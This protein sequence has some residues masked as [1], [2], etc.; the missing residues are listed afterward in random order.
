MTRNADMAARFTRSMMPTYGAPAISLD[1]GDGCYVYDVE[2]NAYLD[3]IA[4]IA[5]SSLGHNH[6][7]I[8]QAVKHQVDRLAHSSNLY[9]H[10]PG[11]ALA[12]KLIELVDA[13]AKVFFVNSGAEANECALKLAIR[14][15]K[16]TGRRYFVAA[17]DG[18]HG[19]TLGAL[20]LSGKASIREPFGPYGIDVHFVPYGDVD[21]IQAA[22]SSECAAV[23]IEP[24][25]GE[26][27]VVWPS[28][29]YLKAV[30]RVCDG[31]GALYIADEIQSGI[32][33]SGQWFAYHESQARPDILTLAKGLAGGLPLGACIALSPYGEL[34]DKGA[35]GST[36]G[37]N[38]VS[39]AAAMAVIETIEKQDLV[40]KSAQ[41]GQHLMDS[42]EALDH[43]LIDEVRGRGLWCAIVLASDIAGPVQDAMA[44]MGVLVN[45]VRPNIIRLAPPLITTTIHIGRF[46]QTLG[47]ALDEVNVK[48]QT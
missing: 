18:F 12:E 43:A 4:G 42:I 2:G 26:A 14:H 32:A 47:N 9:S 5:V 48:E 33:R 44:R 28:P 23:F 37:G 38:P 10:E 20:A 40:A 29:D 46:V 31:T 1:H 6:P 41:T 7:A 8:S 39:C 34:F 36:F 27:G 11:L 21:A 16:V 15:A 3:F 24:A 22:V 17:H 13:P 35:H 30:R 45:A 25:Q 19:R